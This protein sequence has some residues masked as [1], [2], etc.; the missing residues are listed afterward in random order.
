VVSDLDGVNTE[1]S[2]LLVA[3]P[4]SLVAISTYVVGPEGV[5]SLLPDVGTEP[6]PDMLTDDAF[7]VSH[8]R[9]DTSPRFRIVT[10]LASNLMI[11]GFEAQLD[12]IKL[13]PT[14]KG[15]TNNRTR[16]CLLSIAAA[17]YMPF[18]SLDSPSY[19]LQKNPV[20][21]F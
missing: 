17:S 9:V 15:E 8:I 3:L 2:S 21:S 19:M 12:K 4:S 13:K 18:A 7:S 20:A 11:S 16:K 5:T 6:I 1:T 10:G 14:T